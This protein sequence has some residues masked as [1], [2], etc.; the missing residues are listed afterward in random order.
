[1]AESANHIVL[2]PST[3]ELIDRI[4]KATGENKE[5]SLRLAVGIYFFERY[6]EDDMDEEEF[7]F[8]KDL[9]ASQ[10]SGFDFDSHLAR[11]EIKSELR[12]AHQNNQVI[13]VDE[14][15]AFIRNFTQESKDWILSTAVGTYYYDYQQ[16]L[17]SITEKNAYFQALNAKRITPLILREQEQRAVKEGR[18]TLLRLLESNV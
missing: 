6:N 10:Q 18:K 11:T 14:M 7:V 5:W 1:M 9:K 4:S 12:T 17:D 8:F 2:T 16:P 15:L 13:S 3:D